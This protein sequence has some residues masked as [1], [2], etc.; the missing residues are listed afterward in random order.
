MV[1]ALVFDE[2]RLLE[3]YLRRHPKHGSFVFQRFALSIIGTSTHV[4]QD[5]Q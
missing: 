3:S 4:N 2:Q 1:F 5:Y